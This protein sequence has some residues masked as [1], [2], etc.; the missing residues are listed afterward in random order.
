MLLQVLG[1]FEHVV[2]LLALLLLDE[3]EAL[4]LGVEVEQVGTALA[5]LSADLREAEAGLV[6]LVLLQRQHRV[7]A[8]SPRPG[9][10]IY[11]VLDRFLARVMRQ[12]PGAHGE[13]PRGLERSTIA[14]VS[15][16]EPSPSMPSESSGSPITRSISFSSQKAF[17]RCTN[18]SRSSRAWPQFSSCT[19]SAPR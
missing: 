13:Q 12:P 6:V 8:S 11:G 17:R 2:A 1:R 10:L 18:P 4:G 14:R 7:R 19:K 3:Q 16:G 15:E 9:S 5:R